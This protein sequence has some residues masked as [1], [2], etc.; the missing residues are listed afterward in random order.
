MLT[1]LIHIYCMTLIVWNHQTYKNK[2][3]RN[4]EIK[5][6]TTR[7]YTENFAQKKK[8]KKKKKKSRNNKNYQSGE[9]RSQPLF[10]F[11]CGA[12]VSHD[13]LFIAAAWGVSRDVIHTFY[14][15]A[16]PNA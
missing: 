13:N 10:T 11:A 7:T 15:I 4:K 12:I 5:G 3:E 6:K 14:D 1:T 16:V 8:K 9:L 2:T